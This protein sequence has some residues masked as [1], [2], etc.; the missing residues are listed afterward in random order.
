MAKEY[1]IRIKWRD[2]RNELREF[3]TSSFKRALELR[4][5]K[6]NKDVEEAVPI[7]SE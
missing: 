4:K 3:G 5:L 1:G 6:K 2:G 7:T